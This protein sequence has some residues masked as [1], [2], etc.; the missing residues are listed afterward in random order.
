MNWSQSNFSLHLIVVPQF[1]L[2]GFCYLNHLMFWSIQFQIVADVCRRDHLIQV[3]HFIIVI[4]DVG[5]TSVSGVHV[6]IACGRHVF[7]AGGR[8]SIELGQDGVGVLKR[9]QSRRR[10]MKRSGR[11]KK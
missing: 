11:G 3:R 9:H 1:F 6:V 2:L 8:G 10:S 4:V 5:Q 7:F